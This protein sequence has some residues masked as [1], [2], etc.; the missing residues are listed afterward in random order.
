MSPDD[1]AIA[2]RRRFL[3]SAAA[4]GGAGLAMPFGRALAA[5]PP[6]VA[7]PFANGERPLVQYPQKRP[8]I[9]QTSR[10][11]QLETPFS[12][13][14]EGVL[15]PNDAFFVRYHWANIPTHVDPASYRIAVQGK[16][17]KP[18]SLSLQQ[19]KH[20]FEPVEVVAVNQCSGNS[21]GLVSP[22][23]GGGQLGN[24]AMGNARWRGVR[25]RD[26]LA[27]AGVQAGATQVTFNGLDTPVLPQ[28]P[29]FI[30]ALDIDHAN[31]GEV[32]LA[33]AMNG[34]DLP[35]LNGYPVRL[36]VPGYFG[37]YWVKHVAE[38]KVIDGS[39]DGFFMATAYRLPDNACACEKPGALAPK[40]RPIGHFAVRS[41][42]TNLIDGAQVH[43]GKETAVRGIAFDGGQGIREVALSA[44]GGK[45]WQATRLGKDLGRYSFREW[46]AALR[47]PAGAHTLMARATS[48][49]GETQ[50]LDPLWNHAGYRRNV[51]EAVHVAA[52]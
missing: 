20:D 21:R 13:Y 7:L 29:D 4:L 25:L 48:N 2:A 16:V 17:G 1:R 30:K 34:A 3:F 42:I 12:V 35:L 33:Y 43:A 26:V 27:K 15:T 22:R 49:G 38:I 51:V 44:D 28:S 10:P 31:D 52:V 39:F 23:T 8:L 45:T 18:L 40:T 32:M 11:V 36:V 46:N 47:L 19:L 50:P 41:F 14:D 9:R 37:T 5:A 6:M 24:G